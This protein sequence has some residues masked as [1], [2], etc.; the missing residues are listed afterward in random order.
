MTWDDV[1]SEW[2][3]Q[4]D[5]ARELEEEIT[6]GSLAALFE[7]ATAKRGRVQHLIALIKV[8]AMPD[9]VIARKQ[10]NLDRA[11]REWIDSIRALADGLDLD[12][13]CARARH[14]R[15]IAANLE[16]ELKEV[17]S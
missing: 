12:G 15:G 2:R 17:G 6:A 7:D 1:R 9:G 8:E 11:V 14:F 3:A 16:R 13:Q 5:R 10:P 4:F